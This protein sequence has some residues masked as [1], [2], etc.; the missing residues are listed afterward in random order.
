[1][2]T[3]KRKSFGQD[4]FDGERHYIVVSLCD[5]KNIIL[6]ATQGD[7]EQI[8]CGV[9]VNNTVEKGSFVKIKNKFFIL[10]EGPASTGV[11]VCALQV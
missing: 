10:M 4:H 1:M 8:W 7:A 11:F 6:L 2:N 5:A 9:C 3:K